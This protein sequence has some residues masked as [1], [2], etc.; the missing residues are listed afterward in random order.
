[1]AERDLRV[2]RTLAVRREGDPTKGP[3]NGSTK[4]RRYNYHSLIFGYGRWPFDICETDE[5]RSDRMKHIKALLLAAGILA[6]WPVV[7]DAQGGVIFTNLVLFYGTNGGNPQT[8]LV[9]GADGNFY[10]TAAL[11]CIECPQIRTVFRVTFD[12]LLTNLATIIG[13]SKIVP[14]TVYFL[15]A[16]NS[17][18]Y[19]TASGN[20]V[21]SVFQ[22]TTDDTFTTLI[23]F[24]GTNG[25]GPGPLVQ[26]TDGNF[27]GATCY[28]GPGYN[29]PQ[30]NGNGTLFR[31]A[32]D[33]TFTN[34]FFFNGT[35]GVFPNTLMQGPDGNFY[36]TT[37]GGGAGYIDPAH[38]SYG[39]V[40]KVAMDGTFT[41]LVSF[42]GTNGEAPAGLVQG[43][44]GSFYGWTPY[45]GPAYADGHPK[46]GNGTVFKVTPDGTFTT[47]VFFTG[48]NGSVPNCLLKGNDG[49]LYGTTSYGGTGFSR[50]P[51]G[52]TGYGTVFKLTPDGTLTT[53]ALF[54]ET[55]GYRP[56]P[57]LVQATDGS[58]CGTTL[59]GGA[60]ITQDSTG[61][62]FG[63]AF[64]AT[65]G[66]TLTTL[67]SFNG[68][69]GAT[70][71]SL[72][73]G[74][75]GNF[76][77]TTIYGGAG[78][79]GRDPDY[80]FLTGYGTVCRLS[81]PMPAVFQPVTQTDD[82]ALAFTWSAVA[83]QAY[84]LQY[85]TDLTSSNWINLGDAVMATNGTMSA[86]DT[87]GSDS[88]RFY[89]V[90]LLP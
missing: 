37:L 45:G 22:I 60:S 18:L 20:G 78:W 48:T 25:Y 29:G 50:P 64:Q 35:N 74:T 67:A 24:D 52:T 10:G 3:E 84:Q 71:N 15:L 31:I 46:A 33:G 63:T 43:R 87:I 81:V 32:P 59:Y 77:V 42:A 76:Y 16:T 23:S 83:G 86:S 27:Y 66:G 5:N 21:G 28:G 49:N 73:R 80:G 88:Q 39:T 90:V 72:V 8:G 40:F 47:L 56:V 65:S 26:G 34:L 1:M 68:T 44:D 89:R 55:I 57:G 41:T 17:C 6:L 61:V 75:D 14:V 4:P 82:G 85:N 79:R 53:L 62:G 69:N 38:N 2:R 11:T 54:N 13:S 30:N 12:G 7:P 36:G 9:Q 19:G 58:L 51:P 70:P